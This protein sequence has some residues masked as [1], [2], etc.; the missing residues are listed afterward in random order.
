MGHS[1]I[2]I[3][4]VDWTDSLVWMLNFSTH[5]K[6]QQSSLI[7]F[8]NLDQCKIVQYVWSFLMISFSVGRELHEWCR[9]R[10]KAAPS[11]ISSSL[12]GVAVR[13]LLIQPSPMWEEARQCTVLSKKV[14]RWWSCSTGIALQQSSTFKNP[15]HTYKFP[16]QGNVFLWDN[17]KC[18]YLIKWPHITFLQCFMVP[19]TFSDMPSFLGNFLRQAIVFPFHWKTHWDSERLC[20]LL[21]VIQTGAR[22]R[23]W[24]SDLVFRALCFV[25]IF[26]RIATSKGEPRDK[27][28]KRKLAF[29]P[30]KAE[31]QFINNLRKKG[32]LYYQKI[33]KVYGFL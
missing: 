17:D 3:F 22:T 6:E 9:A 32:C 21:K 14:P 28:N 31:N 12:M 26:P 23:A 4:H 18:L 5:R 27:K 1:Y 20:D 10:E 8:Y 15:F 2:D 11:A 7:Q 30:I 29:I 19:K 25:H 16:S 33:W 13:L 24:F